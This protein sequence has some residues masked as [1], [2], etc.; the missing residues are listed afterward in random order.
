MLS[1]SN[2]AIGVPPNAL[3]SGADLKN[4]DKAAGPVYQSATTIRFR[5]TWIKYWFTADAA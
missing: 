3:W 1:S 5:T 2:Y 4:R